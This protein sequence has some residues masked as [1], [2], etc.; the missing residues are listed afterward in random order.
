MDVEEFLLTKVKMEQKKRNKR[1]PKT[2][3][4]TEINKAI[5]DLKS[6][7]GLTTSKEDLIRIMMKSVYLTGKIEGLNSLLKTK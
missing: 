5:E 3:M 6:I 2:Y 7:M 4:N 1:T